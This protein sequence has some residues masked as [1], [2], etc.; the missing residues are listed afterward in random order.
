MT[1]LME[2]ID[3]K[4]FLPRIR[5]TPREAVTALQPGVE[6][7]APDRTLT[8]CRH[9]GVIERLDFYVAEL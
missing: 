4:C 6:W 5:D 8:S 9:N 7:A 2:D 3:V 1:T